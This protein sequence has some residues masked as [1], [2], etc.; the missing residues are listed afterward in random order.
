MYPPPHFQASV[1]WPERKKNYSPLSYMVSSRMAIGMTNLPF[2]TSISDEA[3]TAFPF[4]HIVFLQLC[5][6][7]AVGL[8]IL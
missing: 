2:R 1:T 5:R 3:V 4:I 8:T 6:C 7:N